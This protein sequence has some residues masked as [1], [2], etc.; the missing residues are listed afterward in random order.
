MIITSVLQTI[1][2]TEV[3]GMELGEALRAPRLHQQWSPGDTVFEPG[4]DALLLQ[5]LRNRGHDVDVSTR[6]QAGVQAIRLTIGGEP[7][8]VADPRT[9]LATVAP[10]GREPSA[11]RYVHSDADPRWAQALRKPGRSLDWDAL[12]APAGEPAQP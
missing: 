11:S 4:W 7:D 8:G 10:E 12:A 5:D 6:R 3:Y 9:P 2:R 1:L